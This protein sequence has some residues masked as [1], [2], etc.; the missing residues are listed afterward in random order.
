MKYTVHALWV[1]C[2]KGHLWIDNK[3][4]DSALSQKVPSKVS[5]Q[6][7]VAIVFLLSFSVSIAIYYMY[8]I[9]CENM[10]FLVKISFHVAENIGTFR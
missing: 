5:Q 4:L 1:Y 2:I 7:T 8:S 3:K 10:F 9:N 6:I